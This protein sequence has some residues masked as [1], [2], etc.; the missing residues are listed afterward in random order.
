MMKMKGHNHLF[1][2]VC[3]LLLQGFGLL[4]C[5]GPSPSF[6]VVKDFNSGWRFHL[7][8]DRAASKAS[9]DDSSWAKIALPHDWSINSAFDKHH[10]TTTQEGALPAGIGWYRKTFRV[11]GSWQDKNVYVAFGGVYRDSKVWINGHL[12]GERP[13][14]HVSFRYLLTP[15]LH[16]GRQGN[17]LSVRVNNGLQ[18]DSRWYTGS[19]I[20][21][22]VKLVVTGKIAVAHWG[23]FITTPLITRDSAQVRVQTTLVNTGGRLAT[24]N[25]ITTIYDSSGKKV[26]SITTKDFGIK[27]SLT[28]LSQ[29]LKVGRPGLWS[30]DDPYLYRA[31]TRVVSAGNTVDHYSTVFGVRHFHFDEAKGFFLNGTHLQIRGVCL[32]E[33]LGGLGTAVSTA[34]ILRRL[35]LLKAMGCNAIRTAH[36]PPSTVFLNLCDRMGFLVMDEAFDVWKKKKVKYDYHIYWDR[37][38]SRDLS[39]QVKRDR[40][41]PSIFI[42]SIGNEIREQFDS[43]GIPMTRELV[44]TLKSLDSTRPVTAALTEMDPAKNFIYKSG[45][46]DVLGINYNHRLYAKL[47]ALFPHQKFVAT[48]TMSALSSRGHYDMPSD[49]I[50]M[51]PKKG[52]KFVKQ[53]NPDHTV[54]AYDNVAAYWGSTHEQTLKALRKYPYMAGLF[55]WSGFDYLGEPMPYPWPA[56]SSY[57]GLIDLAGF[58]KDAYYLYQSL[59]TDKPVLHLF[60]HWNWKPGQVVDVWA[61]YNQADE[62]ELYLNGKSLG[63]RHKQDGQMHVMW[64]VKFVSGILKA[65]SRKNGKVVLTRE[66]KTAGKP[67][68]IKL[69]PDR[70]T[71]KSGGKDLP[72]VTAKILDAHGVPVPD[73]AN[74]IRFRVLGDGA[75]I[76]TN[77][78]FE[79]DLEPFTTDNHRAYNGLCLVVVAPGKKPGSLVI[80]A[81]APGLVSD[82]VRIR[83]Q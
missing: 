54:S 21:R 62:V 38:H 6:R 15:Y 59:W 40:N 7:G 72:F 66:I 1:F 43:T 49:S 29:Q 74:L 34:A 55:V 56:R 51:W 3:L 24:L 37:W 31:V 41:H 28:T 45:A 76:A 63:I 20:N 42:W 44:A 17:V 75:V 80:K 77:N 18:P 60:P 79:G 30:V 16:F 81:S 47:P 83:C 11:P 68:E 57:F 8:D 67:A 78:G 27:D 82:S 23:T 52:E 33:D 10:R 69:Y 2:F 19:G 22:N 5:G 50:R 25:L 26:A 73:A 53:G 4:G 12:L 58:P 32:H 36:N 35:K 64:R 14:G 71:V 9:Y 65:V 48:E 13:N 39:D 46:L 70:T 61:Y